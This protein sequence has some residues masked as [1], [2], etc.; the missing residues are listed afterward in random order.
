MTIAITGA[1]GNIGGAVARALAADGVPFRMIV[2]DA[3]RAPELPGA[4]VAVAT[5]ADA[6]ASRAALEGVDVLLMV[7]AAEAEDRLDQHRTFVAAAAEAGVRHVVYTSFLGAAE[8]ATFTLGRDHWATEQAIRATDTAYTFLRDSFYLDFVEDL[9][10]EDGVIRGPAGDGAMAAV[11]RADVARVATAVLRDPAAHVDRTYELT[12]P[13]A[14]TLAEAAAVVSEVRGRTVTYH[15]ETLDE[16][17]A[18]RAQWNPEPWQADAWVSTYT[19][20]AEGAL[21]H[22]S[23][24]VERITGRRPMSLREVLAGR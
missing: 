8:D 2:R 5:F 11:A 20:I 23:G 21:A 1:T 16:A 13:A 22:V 15:P 12:G 4:E 7:S 10:G 17:Y 6:D 14:I 19:A 9:V 24:D 3:A 18:S